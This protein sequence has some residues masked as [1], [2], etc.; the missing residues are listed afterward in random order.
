MFTLLQ[1]ERKV[2]SSC[3]RLRRDERLCD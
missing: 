3:Y 2:E 1:L